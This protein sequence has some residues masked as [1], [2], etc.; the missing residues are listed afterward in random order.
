MSLCRRNISKQLTFINVPLFTKSKN[1]LKKKFCKYQL[2]MCNYN[3][4]IKKLLRKEKNSTADL[5]MQLTAKVLSA[6]PWKA[7]TSLITDPFVDVRIVLP[8]GLNLIPVQSHSFSMDNWNV[9][10][11]PLSNDLKTYKEHWSLQVSIVN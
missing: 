10:N 2:C 9:L 7:S 3:N 8:S 4:N 6:V 5:E 1:L 11:G